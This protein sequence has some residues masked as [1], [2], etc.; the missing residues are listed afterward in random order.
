M[1]LY[2]GAYLTD[3][4]HLTTEQHGAY[5]LLLMA[6]WKRGGSLPDDDAQLAAI[7][8]LT[9]AQWRKARAVIAPFWTIGR[10]TWTQK[11][12]TVELEKARSYV[13]AQSENGKLGGRPRKATEN[14]PLNPE[15]SQPEAE[16][17]A[18]AKP[19]ETPV[20]LPVPNTEVQPLPEPKSVARTARA[21]AK[22]RL[23][24]DFNVSDRVRQWAEGKGFSRLDEHL[25]HFIGKAK[26]KGYTYADWDEG[27]MGA[28]RDDWAG[29]RKGDGATPL[30]GK[31]W[32]IAGWSQIIA[33]GVELGLEQDRHEGDATYRARIFHAAGITA[34]Q[35][36]KAE[37]DHGVK[38]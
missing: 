2:F 26:A 38:A 17:K 30:N 4:M 13:T 6:C 3:T 28:I 12:L 23:P 5:F 11:R 9:P 19:D 14:P 24:D 25:E 37:L 27:F 10:H 15:E 36:R 20:P 7:A 31:P 8:K 29:L 16:G 22:T 35:V 1:P 34:E 33:K 18:D 21:P 32:F